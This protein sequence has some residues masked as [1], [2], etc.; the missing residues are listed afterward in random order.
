M[1]GSDSQAYRAMAIA[2]SEL[3]NHRHYKGDQLHGLAGRYELTAAR[4]ESEARNDNPPD[5]GA[6]QPDRS[7]WPT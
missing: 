1:S 7:L 5:F 2:L 4:I 3:A 6:M